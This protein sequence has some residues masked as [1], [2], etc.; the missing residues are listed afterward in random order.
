M[1]WS[2]PTQKSADFCTGCGGGFSFL[3]TLRG[4]GADS[5]GI[6]TVYGMQLNLEATVGVSQDSR[7]HALLLTGRS[8]VGRQNMNI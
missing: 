7:Q 2:F 5:Q 8:P 1:R 6:W 4:C 3:G